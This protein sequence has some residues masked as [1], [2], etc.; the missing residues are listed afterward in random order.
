MSSLTFRLKSLPEGVPLNLSALTPDKL[1][2]LGSQELC[3]QNIG[4]GRDQ[5]NAGDVF[6]ISG[7]AS[8]TVT[9]KTDDAPIDYVGGA[10]TGG[11]LIVEGSVGSHAGR[12]MTGGTLEIL[13]DAGD[14]LAARMLGGTIRVKGS[15]GDRIGGIVAG[16]RFGMAGG[17]II[18]EGDIG[19]RAAEKMRRGTIVVKGKTG[20]GTGT[21]MVGG[22]IWTE[23]GLGPNPGYMMRRGTLIA[24][25]APELLPTFV[26]CGTHDLV[27]ARILSRH[28]KAT[29]GA[30]APPALPVMVR[31]FGGDT[32]IIGRGEI[33]VPA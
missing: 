7:S 1:A 15:A 23:K 25:Q 3:R 21:R 28:L 2:K 33:L 11:K 18:V 20:T 4:C 10:M 31:K 14:L 32:S 30:D 24:P 13:G 5:I 6:D 16:D 29:L 22:T 27:I 12:E 9:I 17:V 26:D 8:D 19:D